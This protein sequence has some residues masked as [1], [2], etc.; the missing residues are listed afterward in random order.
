MRRVSLGCISIKISSRSARA[1]RERVDRV[2]TEE[3]PQ[4]QLV[5]NGL[6]GANGRPTASRAFSLHP[7]PVSTMASSRQPK[8]RDGV[9]KALNLFIKTL[10]VAKDAC[11]IP[12]AQV[13]FG[14]AGVLWT[15]IRVRLSLLCGGDL[16]AHIV[17][18][19]NRSESSGGGGGCIT[20]P[21]THTSSKR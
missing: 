16:L 7:P 4:T 13:A 9:L 18:S 17:A 1:T 8:G 12:P 11:G 15:M 20:S 19:C 10:Y 3:D 5:S 6:H 2:K 14:S 21:L